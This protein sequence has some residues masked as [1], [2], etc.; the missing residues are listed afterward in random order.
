MKR[1]WEIIRDLLI[2]I[3]E[4]PEQERAGF[5]YKTDPKKD[6]AANAKAAHAV[7][8]ADAGFLTGANTGFLDGSRVLLAP[9]LN[10]EGHELL[11]TIRS[12]PVWE[13]IKSTAQE[14]GIELTF[15]TV[16]ALGKAALT[17]IISQAN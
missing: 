5:S 13:R 1:D 4:L 3:E 16:I 7:L 17:W 14:K 9:N 15:D 12:K 6:D 2:E 10:W 11:D 8:L